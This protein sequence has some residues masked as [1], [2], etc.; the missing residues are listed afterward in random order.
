MIWRCYL[1]PKCWDKPYLS[2]NVTED[3]LKMEITRCLK[4]LCERVIITPEKDVIK[5]KL[6][7]HCVGNPRRVV[8]T[9]VSSVLQRAL[10]FRSSSLR[11]PA[12]FQLI[13]SQL[14]AA[15]LPSLSRV[16]TRG[17]RKQ[18]ERRQ[19]GRQKDSNRNAVCEKRGRSA[20]QR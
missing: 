7:F 19:E 12:R 6:R 8:L 11:C 14:S 9:Q 20:E 1:Y 17:R 15:A 10:S 5:A 13:R 16:G 3:G 4:V 18:R 2:K